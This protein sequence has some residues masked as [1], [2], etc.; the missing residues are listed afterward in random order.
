VLDPDEVLV[1]RLEKEGWSVASQDGVT[2]ALDTF[3]DD[4]L[5]REARVHELIHHVNSMRRDVGLE[6]TDRIVL[7]LPAADSDLMTH[8]DWIAS[9][10]LATSSLSVTNCR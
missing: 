7:V 3:V 4:D 9:E 1:E 2:V 5:R 8:H 6:I 10:T